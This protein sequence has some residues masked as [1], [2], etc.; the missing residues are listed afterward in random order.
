MTMVGIYWIP[1]GED[2]NVLQSEMRMRTMLS[3]LVTPM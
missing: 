3:R 1:E 2:V